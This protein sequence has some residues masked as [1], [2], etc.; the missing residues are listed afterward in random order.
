MEPADGSE[1][2]VNPPYPVA[3]EDFKKFLRKFP[4]DPFFYLSL[5]L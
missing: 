5:L 3:D 2:S 4:P 1:I